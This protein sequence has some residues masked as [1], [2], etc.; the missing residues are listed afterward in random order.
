MGW[1]ERQNKDYRECMAEIVGVLKKYDMAGV[2]HVVSKERSMWKY[3]MPTWGV[4]KLI[5]GGIHIYSKRED[6]PSLEAQ[7]EATELSAHVV[8][9]LRDLAALEFKH[10]D[11]VCKAFE[12]RFDVDHQG[13]LDFDPEHDN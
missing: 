10:F 3:H 1:G 9:Q 5:D 4:I 2:V 11:G 6:F 7:K 8:F 13:G 12:S